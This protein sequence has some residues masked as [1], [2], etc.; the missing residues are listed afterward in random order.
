MSTEQQAPA[1]SY[2]DRSRQ[3][4]EERMF[5]FPGGEYV[6]RLKDY[7][8]KKSKKKKDMFELYFNPISA[9]NTEILEKARLKD[10]QIVARF[11]MDVDFQFD[12]FLNLLE[13]LG[14]DLSQCRPQAQDPTFQDFQAIMDELERI[15]PDLK[16]ELKP[17]EDDP[18]YYDVY[19]RDLVEILNTT[20]AATTATTTEPTAPTDTPA[21]PFAFY[22]DGKAVAKVYSEAELQALIDGGYVGKVNIGNAWKTAQEHGFTSAPVAPPEEP[23]AAVD[24]P[25]APEE[26][27]APTE[28]EAPADEPVAPT[29]TPAAD[30][31]TADTSKRPY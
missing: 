16:M 9:P 6:G 27:A 20:P 8:F 13:D 24:E 31:P 1:V 3:A 23:A 29:D 2:A 14:A 17:Q 18:R 19:F 21:A 7:K 10:R 12:N 5:R 15:G 22:M 26:P 4:R 28:P 30:T 11:V 25:A